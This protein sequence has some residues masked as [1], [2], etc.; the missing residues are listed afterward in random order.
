MK[1]FRTIPLLVLLIFAVGVTT[2]SAQRVFKRDV[3]EICNDWEIRVPPFGETD[4]EAGHISI[5]N[6]GTE[7]FVGYYL[8]VSRDDLTVP[9]RFWDCTGDSVSGTI[10]E[11]TD[12]EGLPTVHAVL[13]YETPLEVWTADGNNVID[14][15]VD[16]GLMRIKLTMDFWLPFPGAPLNFRFAS[17]Y[18]IHASGIGYAY[19]TGEGEFA[20][21]ELVEVKL[22]QNGMY[23]P[24]TPPNSAVGRDGWPVE[25][26]LLTSVDY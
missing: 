19:G 16:N 3:S 20:P 4:W 10:F 12:N 26:I 22:I 5:N 14:R 1:I 13:F 17:R 24:Q 18:R 25:K 6:W 11:S 7:D 21:G 15:V 2:V 23:L 8:V 9:Q